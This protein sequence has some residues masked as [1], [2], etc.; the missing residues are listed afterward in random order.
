MPRRIPGKMP[1][2]SIHFAIITPDKAM[3]DPTEISIPPVD[4]TKVI[5]IPQRMVGQ[6]C[7]MEFCKVPSLKKFG[8]NI[9][10]KSKRPAKKNKEA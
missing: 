10:L 9:L 6:S 4:M 7:V 3:R 8:V 1:S 2:P 5:P